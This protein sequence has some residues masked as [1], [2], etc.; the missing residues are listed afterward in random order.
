MPGAKPHSACCKKQTKNPIIQKI[1]LKTKNDMKNRGVVNSYLPLGNSS[2]LAT[3]KIVF[4]NI[5]T[6][7][8]VSLVRNVCLCLYLFYFVVQELWL[9][10]YLD[11]TTPE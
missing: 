4:K 8:D 6:F 9:F 7:V 3:W 1:G 2:Q 10:F 5:F 11:I